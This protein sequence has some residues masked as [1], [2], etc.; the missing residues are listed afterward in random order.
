MPIS[1]YSG[2]FSL[3]VYLSFTFY[4]PTE[5]EFAFLLNGGEHRIN[6][7]QLKNDILYG[8]MGKWI[9]A[10]FLTRVNSN[11]LVIQINLPQILDNLK[12]LHDQSIRLKTHL[13]GMLLM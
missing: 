12:V 10:S 2:Q 11:I 1:R 4:F 9:Y 3:D 7:G 5:I 8:Q 6:L 13:N